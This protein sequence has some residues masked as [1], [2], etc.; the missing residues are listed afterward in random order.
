M[1]TLLMVAML[2]SHSVALT[3]FN[4]A[5][6][7]KTVGDFS[8]E[9]LAQALEK[10]AVKT[11]TPRAIAA[12]IGNDRQ[13]QLLGCSETCVTELAGALG[14]D[15]LVLGDV[16]RLGSDW[17]LNVR[18]VT[19]ATAQS[20]ATFNER[21]STEEGIPLM[22]ER[23]AWAL[24]AQLVKAGWTEV[25]VGAE[26]MAPRFNRLWA[27]APAVVGVAGLS[28]GVVMELQADAQLAT[29]KT[30]TTPGAVELARTTG[31]SNEVLATASLIVGGA[32]IVTAVI[33][34]LLGDSPHVTPVAWVT[35][36]SSGLG[37]AGVFP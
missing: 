3:T 19:A 15:A 16:A 10:H 32:G 33:V 22:I 34:F 9:L 7:E 12:V 5:P 26:P 4:A 17:A 35:P 24:S 13:R 21:T 2:G 23:A 37:L 18:V 29:L 14:V 1:L 36:S 31:H 11:M 30:A 28:L 27:I 25:S 6:S 8:G 20:I